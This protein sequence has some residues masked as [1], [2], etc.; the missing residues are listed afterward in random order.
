MNSKLS[1]G[2]RVVTRPDVPATTGQQ[3]LCVGTSERPR[4]VVLVPAV[5]RVHT[6][7]HQLNVLNSQLSP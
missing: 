6:T 2:L 1:F 3:Q 4:R 7:N 5:V